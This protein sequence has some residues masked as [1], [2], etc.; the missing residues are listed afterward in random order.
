MVNHRFS[1]I[2]IF[3]RL[4]R[5]YL[6]IY[7][8]LLQTHRAL[9]GHHCRHDHRCPR[10]SLRKVAEATV[11]EEIGM[12]VVMGIFVIGIFEVFAYE[13]GPLN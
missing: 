12:W 3:D 4:I 9:D 13:V 2:F 10:S 5:Y 6:W 7:P 11:A 1:D 8:F